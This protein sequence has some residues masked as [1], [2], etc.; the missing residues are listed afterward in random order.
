M[1]ATLPR[2]LFDDE[3]EDH[4]SD[5]PY[6][7]QGWFDRW[8]SDGLITEVLMPLKRGKEASVYLCRAV[9]RNTGAE[10]LAAKVFRPRQ[11][12][13]FKDRSAYRHG[14]VILNGHDRRAFEAKTKYGRQFDEAVWRNHE[15]ETLSALSEA[16]ADVPKPVASAEDGILMQYVGDQ[17]AP[18]PQLRDVMLEASEA[19]QVFDRLM[20][21]VELFLSKNLVH[22]DL[23]P[24]NVLF[25]EGRVTVIDLPQA[26]DAR[27]N[28]NSRSLLLRDIDN[29][30]RFFARF[31]IRA[32]AEHIAN[33]LWRRFVFAKL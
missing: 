11:S 7:P 23:S 17:E 21:N 20:W 18:A 27:T 22:A 19:R 28:M 5:G 24:Y 2:P 26:V 14:M 12:R 8:V 30:C 10:L 4:L 31:G 16:G 15:Y 32:D 25:W 6:G 13:G 1:E 3:Y 33:D 29:L 9:P